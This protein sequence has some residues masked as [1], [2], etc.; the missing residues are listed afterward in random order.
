MELTGCSAMDQ[1]FKTT[2]DSKV[3]ELSCSHKSHYGVFSDQM[4]H[5][6]SY[7]G[8]YKE[9]SSAQ[10]HRE[11]ILSISDQLTMTSMMLWQE[12]NQWPKYSNVFIMEAWRERDCTICRWCCIHLRSP[13]NENGLDILHRKS[14]SFTIAH[15][16]GLVH[17][18]YNG[19]TVSKSALTLDLPFL[20]FSG[21]THEKVPAFLPAEVTGKCLTTSAECE[22]KGRG[23]EKQAEK[24]AG[25]SVLHL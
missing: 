2:L 21:E 4:H 11:L 6:G 23:K 18:N 1:A 16:P 15:W 22:S 25:Y 5:W 14:V 12:E 13:L 8:K 19:K 7:L 24:Q 17:H 20:F 9:R 10:R 3:H